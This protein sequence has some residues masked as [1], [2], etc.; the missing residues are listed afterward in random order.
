MLI[1]LND[2]LFMIDSFLQILGIDNMEEFIQ[3]LADVFTHLDLFFIFMTRLQ[4]TFKSTKLM[5]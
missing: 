2:G 3:P 4:I 1:F 5:N